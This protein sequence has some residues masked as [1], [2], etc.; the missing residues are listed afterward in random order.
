MKKILFTILAVALTLTAGAQNENAEPTKQ[1]KETLNALYLTAGIG[2]SQILDYEDQIESKSVISGHI[3]VKYDRYKD[4]NGW[5]QTAQL[6]FYNKGWRE[7]KDNFNKFVINIEGNETYNWYSPKHTNRWQ[8]GLGPFI[9]YA[10]AGCFT[11]QGQSGIH[12]L[13]KYYD[14]RRFD[15]GLGVNFG[16]YKGRWYLGMNYQQGLIPISSNTVNDTT[17]VTY[18]GHFTIGYKF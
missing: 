12:N 18:S 4:Q 9:E 13:F 6:G 10:F 15:F 7:I 3:G 14:V 5:G 8:V 17:P 2:A 16:C 11:M 1:S